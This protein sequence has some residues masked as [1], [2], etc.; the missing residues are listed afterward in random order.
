MVN[1]PSVRPFAGAPEVGELDFSRAVELPENTFLMGA[2][3]GFAL[4]GD[5][6][7]ERE[8]H[9]FILP[10]GRGEW[11]F[12]AVRE[13]FDYAAQTGTHI[14]LARVNR[15]LPHVRIYARKAGMKPTGACVDHFDIYSAELPSCLP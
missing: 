9:V 14:L 15:H 13:A 7:V 1:H 11:G 3:G 2:Y 8:I 6:P 10:E 5:D 4:C 12:K